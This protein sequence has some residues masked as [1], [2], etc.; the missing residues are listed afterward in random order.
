MVLDRH[1]VSQ[2]ALRPLAARIAS[3]STLRRL[4]SSAV[5]TLLSA[6]PGWLRFGLTR[7]GG[8]ERLLDGVEGDVRSERDDPADDN[9]TRNWALHSGVP[10]SLKNR[11]ARPDLQ[12]TLLVKW[13]LV[14]S[15]GH[16][17]THSLPCYAVLRVTP[18][19]IEAFPIGRV[20]SN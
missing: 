8:I 1:A 3:P 11:A 19:I 14:Y 20:D 2:A 18:L 6:L 15:F 10:I 5:T 16:T 7:V 4:T 9:W 13:L 17:L 12:P